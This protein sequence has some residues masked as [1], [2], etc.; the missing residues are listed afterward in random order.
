MK[1]DPDVV[2][3]FLE[4]RDKC[5]NFEINTCTV[6]YPLKELQSIH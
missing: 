4:P 1:N 6:G 3:K 5:L 2:K